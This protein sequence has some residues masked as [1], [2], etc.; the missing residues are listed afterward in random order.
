MKCGYENTH[1]YL[2]ILP[3]HMKVKYLNSNMKKYEDEDF[4][5]HVGGTMSLIIFSVA[6]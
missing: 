1:V 3:E 6:A 5:T 2:S 4:Q